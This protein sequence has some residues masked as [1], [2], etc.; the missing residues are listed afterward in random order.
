MLPQ[1]AFLTHFYANTMEG[2]QE[3]IPR[4]AYLTHFSTNTEAGGASDV[5]PDALSQQYLARWEGNDT[6][7]LLPHQ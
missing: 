6:P 7:G 2:E 5:L 3:M 4:T 1:T